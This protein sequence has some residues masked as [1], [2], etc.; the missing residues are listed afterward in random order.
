MRHWFGLRL[1]GS[2]FGSH[3]WFDNWFR[4]GCDQSIF[5]LRQV[6][7]DWFRLGCDGNS[8]GVHNWFDNWLGRDRSNVD[9]RHGLGYRCNRDRFRLCRNRRNGFDNWFRFDG[10]RFWLSRDGYSVDVRDGFGN[11]LRLGRDGSSVDVRNRFD[12]GFRF[13]L[14]RDRSRLDMRGSGY[15]FRL[16]DNWFRLHGCSF[17]VPYRLDHRFQ[18]GGDRRRF[19]RDRRGFDVRKGFRL[20][21]SRNWSDRDRFGLQFDDFGSF[22]GQGRR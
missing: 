14:N 18:F 2:S 7:D 3:N 13:P 20:W 12:G 8:F 15:R 10:D 6:C 5:G 22:N 19:S 21:L 16:D 17:D 1:D 9:T 4:F 11:G